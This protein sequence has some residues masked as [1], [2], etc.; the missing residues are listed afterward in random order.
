MKNDPGGSVDR[1]SIIQGRN[2]IVTPFRMELAAT[3]AQG[4]CV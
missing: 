1:S 3:R 2:S 4:S